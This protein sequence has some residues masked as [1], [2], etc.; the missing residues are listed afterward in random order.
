M[1]EGWATKR[2]VPHVPHTTAKA[3]PQIEHGQQQERVGDRDGERE[4]GG[5]CRQV[6]LILLYAVGRRIQHVIC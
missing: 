2:Q 3:Q 6:S 5:L 4:R 1:A